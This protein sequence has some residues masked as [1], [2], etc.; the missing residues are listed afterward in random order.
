MSPYQGFPSG[1]VGLTR[2][3]RPFFSDLL[4]EIDHL[5]EL[6]VTLYTF[7]RLDRMEGDFRYLRRSDYLKDARF[8]SGMGK[9]LKEAEDNL[10]DALERAVMR[11]VLLHAT[12]TLDNREEDYYFINSPKGRAAI[13]AMREGKW[14]PTN[15][16]QATIELDMERPN[17]FRLYEENIGPLTP[18]IADHLSDAEQT[19]S[20]G[21]L[22]EAIHIAVE[23]NKRSW[24]YVAGILRGWQERGRNEQNRR[25]T[26]KDRRSYIE[27]KFADIIKH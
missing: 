16:Q 4:P 26:E 5:G 27:G 2:I 25:D 8:V 22:E 24:A 14:R 18:L 11:G 6:K 13:E 1:K 12:V 20:A 15:D 7:W 17:V 21:W 3:P 9:S 19:Y 10:A 23:R